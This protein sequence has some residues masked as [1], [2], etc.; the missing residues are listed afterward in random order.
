MAKRENRPLKDE[1]EPAHQRQ[2]VTLG[3][4]SSDFCIPNR[5]GYGSKISR[6]TEKKFN[7]Q[8][9]FDKL[10]HAG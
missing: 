9:N 7:A 2:K 10:S 6:F 5:L 4:G 8:T 1:V 3:E